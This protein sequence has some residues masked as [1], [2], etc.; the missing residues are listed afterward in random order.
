LAKHPIGKKTSPGFAD[1]HEPVRVD[2]Q[3]SAE[4]EQAPAARQG[5][6]VQQPATPVGGVPPLREKPRAEPAPQPVAPAPAARRE[7]A[8]SQQRDSEADRRAQAR[9]VKRQPDPVEIEVIHEQSRAP[10][11][12]PLRRCYEVWTQNT[13]YAVDSRMICVEVRTPSTG[14]VKVDHP[15][16]GARLVGGQL[17]E[18]DAIEMSYPLPRPGSFAVFESR[19]HNRRTFSR[20]SSVE[21]VVLRMRIVTMIEASQ[22][23]DW[24]GFS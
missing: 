14:E 23:P 11:P 9:P 16:L 13:V 4:T 1:P 2:R 21:R 8:P 3:R 18:A 22:P 12:E 24:D 15:F 19:K 17:Q 20:T 5:A 6:V 10:R 7:S